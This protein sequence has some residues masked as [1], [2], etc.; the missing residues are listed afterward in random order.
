DDTAKK[1]LALRESDP[2]VQL[3]TFS[4]NVGYQSSVYAG[5][6]QA[7]GDLVLVI[8]VDCEDPPELLPE[9]LRAVDDGHDVVY[10]IRGRRDEPLPVTL[11]RKIF[12]RL[13][14]LLADS[15]I[16]LDMAE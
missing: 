16:I 5:L 1:I 6:K 11:A 10:G 2:R 8:D 9:F 13:T 12:Y 4:R 15:D 3:L 7:R 14:K